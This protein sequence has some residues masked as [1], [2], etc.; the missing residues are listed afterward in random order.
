MGQLSVL[1]HCYNNLD[2]HFCCGCCSSHSTIF[3][4]TNFVCEASLLN[5]N[6]DLC[7]GCGCFQC[8]TQTDL[9][10][11]LGVPVDHSYAVVVGVCDVDQLALTIHAQAPRFV[12]MN[13]AAVTPSNWPWC[14][15]TQHCGTL[16]TFDVNAL[17]LWWNIKKEEVKTEKKNTTH[18]QSAARQDFS[19]HDTARKLESDLSSSS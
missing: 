1:K 12:E 9:W 18:E 10:Y 6:K 2:Y 19:A 7:S 14:A 3:K 15:C 5:V 17:D 16:F 11:C 13:R 8:G 4:L